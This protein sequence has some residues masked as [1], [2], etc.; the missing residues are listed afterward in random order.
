M[1]IRKSIPAYLFLLPA[2]LSLGV[3]KLF[4][5]GYGVYLSLHKWGLVKERFVG[6]ANY[7]TL[8]RD[9][10]F[11]S[12]LKVTVYYVLGVVPFQ[13]LLGLVIAFLLYQR[14]RGRAA[15]RLVYFLPF[16]TSMVAIGL[17]WG[18]IFN[19]RFGFINS[20]LRSMGLSEPR[21]LLEPSGVISLLLKPLGLDVPAWLQGPSLALVTI[22]IVTVWHYVGFNMVVF[23][24]S[25]TAIPEELYHAA[26]LDGASRFQVFRRIT[27]PLLSPTTFMLSIIS[28]IG[29]FESFAL[30]YVMTGSGY[31]M[32]GSSG[33]PLGTTRVATLFIFDHFYRFFHVGYGAAAAVALFLIIL[34]LVIIQMR[35]GG[36]RVHYLGG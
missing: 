29:A 36:R 35:V 26:E 30:V 12:S 27:V 4:A 34:S 15:Y 18:W 32:T 11:W 2:G 31:G 28:T 17:V 33:E 10:E 21:W 6:L 20:V 22:I 14:I 3:F 25:L 5:L 24:A 1:G 23:L 16:V 13:I 7:T 19:E 9:S 8:M